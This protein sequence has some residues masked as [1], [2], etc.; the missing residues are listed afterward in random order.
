MAVMSR[1]S[2]VSPMS[3][4]V[5]SQYARMQQHA[6]ASQRSAKRTTSLRNQPPAQRGT[7]ACH[8]PLVARV[9]DLCKVARRFISAVPHLAKPVETGHGMSQRSQNAPGSRAHLE[10]K[11]DRPPPTMAPTCTKGDSPS[12]TRPAASTNMALKSFTAMVF[13]ESRPLRCTPLKYAL[14]ASPI[15]CR[16]GRHEDPAGATS[17]WAHRISASPEPAAWGA[18]KTT[19]ALAAAPYTAARPAKAQNGA[20]SPPDMG[21]NSHLTAQGLAC[22]TEDAQQGA[23]CEE[24][25]LACPLNQRVCQPEAQQREGRGCLVQSE[26][27]EAHGEPHA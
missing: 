20:A 9:T 27:N 2:C 14:H 15:E 5:F 17:S 4:G 21:W 7:F 22:P 19:A 8:R 13:N 1:C 23:T 18:K 12:A 26:R 16:R 6:V 11:L 10:P 3:A 24:R 25:V